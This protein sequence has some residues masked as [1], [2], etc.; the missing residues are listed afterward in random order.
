MMH[1]HELRGC[2]PVP[3]AHYLKALAIL[4]L[5]GE[6][7][8][9][10]A[11]GFWKDECFWLVTK[12]SRDE[13]EGFFL[14]DYSPTP[15]LA[16]WNG[17][18]GFYPK[19]NQEALRAF[20]ASTVQR[21]AA[22]RESC[23][24]CRSVVG[25]TTESPKNE[26]KAQMIRELRAAARTASGAWMDAAVAL[27]GSGDP[28][29]PALLGTGGNDG[30]LDFTNNFMQR[31]SEV[32]LVSSE[33]GGAAPQARRLLESAL[34]SL[35]SRGLG[36]DA[37]GQFL[38][39]AAG[40]ANST[41]GYAGKSQLNPFDFIL[42]LEGAVC[43]TASI[44][45]RASPRGAVQA[46]APFATRALSASYGSACASDESAR[47]EQW[48][49]LWDAPATWSET[50]NLFREGRSQL[51]TASAQTALDF[52]RS[53]SRMGTARGIGQF[54]RYGYQERNGQANLA[55]PL[56]RWKV[57]SASQG[58][59]IDEVAPWVETLRRVAADDRAPKVFERAARGC[60]AALM[61]CC[62]EETP[63]VWQDLL[64]RL[65]RAE[66]LALSSPKFAKDKNLRPL[67]T[68]S[69]G[70]LEMM[71]DGSAEVRLAAAI[72]NLGYKREK[73][74]RS[75]R[76][77]WLPLDAYGTKFEMGES[78]LH[79]GPERVGRGADLVD[80]L[81]AVL[82][83]RAIASDAGR[84]GLG[85][86]PRG[87]C[88]ASVD[89]VARFLEDSSFDE[90]KCL[91]L[92]LGLMA[93]DLRGAKLV[94]GPYDP[95]N[96][97]ASYGV[98]R[99]AVPLSEPADDEHPVR[100]E[101]SILRR[102]GADDAQEALGSARRRL[103]A[104]GI[105]PKAWLFPTERGEGRRLLASLCFPLGHRDEERLRG[106]LLRPEREESTTEAPA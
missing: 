52:A 71:V 27:S 13:L 82:M 32:F 50:S 1:V 84:T 73:H 22:Y 43:F 28:S 18:S 47:G 44:T 96:V 3:L 104:A 15:L 20:E 34:W 83:R 31:L 66:R 86:F 95:S 103:V 60:A 65:A 56:E 101:P 37:V 58:A 70:W 76:D 5:V 51:A 74:T 14:K 75:I 79:V 12:L 38:P 21:F 92:A 91:E 90:R 8:D 106:R 93:G 2:A 87:G 81:C 33:E 98:L 85:L 78:G 67:P 53:L 29:Y 63:R 16:P 17:G 80:D 59:L 61:Q 69:S 9:P 99:L 7:V 4:R 64:R 23:S 48:M 25:A 102:L 94:K 77:Y 39:G 35:P 105:R 42:G 49:P 68:L 41:E 6:Q 11:R 36:D 97:P 26:R 57:H 19:D 55:V 10:S 46:S 89:D 62:R 45:R 88:Y 72:A 40:G 30:R 54:Q 24:L 100:L